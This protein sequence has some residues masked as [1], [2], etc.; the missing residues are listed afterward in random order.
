LKLLKHAN[1]LK[2]F[3]ITVER[4]AQPLRKGT[5][6]YAWIGEALGVL[7]LVLTVADSFHHGVLGK[8]VAF[9]RKKK[10]TADQICR[11]RLDEPEKILAFYGESNPNT[12]SG[13]AVVP[14]NDPSTGRK[15]RT[16]R[17][18]KT[19]RKRAKRPSKKRGKNAA[20]AKAQGRRKR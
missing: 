7:G 15:Q 18:N 10:I 19:G 11:L 6:A 1:E 5:D 14:M 12:G 2:K 13:A 8:A 17:S 20:G 9:L 16:A 3:G 4:D